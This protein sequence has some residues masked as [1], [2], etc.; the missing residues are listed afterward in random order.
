[1]TYLAPILNGQG[2]SFK[3]VETSQEK[4]LDVVV[5]YLQYKYIIELKIWRGEKQHQKGLN[6]L[7][8]YLD[9]HSVDHGYLLIFDT[10]KD[11][12]WAVEEIEHQ[13]KTI[14]AV[15]V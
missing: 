12:D 10:R 15:W 9:I 7:A 3:E 11:K 2:H 8:D 6:Q 5:T 14:D 13:G 4:R 1:M